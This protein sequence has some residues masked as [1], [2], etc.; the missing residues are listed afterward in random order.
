MKIRILALWLAVMVA[1]GGC[2]QSPAAPAASTSAA[3]GGNA[4]SGAWDEKGAVEITMGDGTFQAA[5]VGTSVKDKVLTITAGGTYVLSGR[6]DDG[7]IVIDAEDKDVQL[8]LN[9]ASLTC[10]DS[11][12]IYAKGGKLTLTL[13]EGTENTLSDGAEY[14]FAQGEDEPTGAVF[15]KDDLTIG[16][17]GT[18]T[19]NGRYQHGIAGKDDVAIDGG[20]LNVTAKADGIRGKDSLTV[21]G[22]TITVEAG[23]DGLK[24]NNNED[25]SK[26]MVTLNGGIL[27]VTAGNDAV[28]AET[29]LLIAD[30]EYQLATGGGGGDGHYQD[31]ASRKGL[32]AGT[33]I[34]VTGGTFILDT[35]DDAVHSNGTVDVSGGTFTISTGDDGIHGDG[36]VSVSGGDINILK[37][38][39]GLEGLNVTV[40]DGVVHLIA[41]DDGINAAD[42]TAAEGPGA[43]GFGGGRPQGEVPPPQGTTPPG[44]GEPPAMPDGI[45]EQAAPQEGGAVSNDTSS[46]QPS[47]EK[48]AP[49]EA[50]SQPVSGEA[51]SGGG[52]ARPQRMGGGGPGGHTVNENVFIRISGGTVVVDAKGDGLDS[53][54]ALYMDGGTVLVNGPSGSG[55]GALDYDGECVVT[56]GTLIAAGSAGMA[57]GISESSAQASLMVYFTETQAADTAVN[58]ST[59]DGKSIVTFVPKKEFQT[60]L[61]S[62]P[63]LK[64]GDT[65]ALSTGGTDTVDEDGFAAGGSWSG[66]E[67][68]AEITL[69]KVTKVSQDGSAVTGGGMMG[70][71]GGGGRRQTPAQ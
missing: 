28:Q 58:L 9:G 49:G 44:E 30:G 65:V 39:E 46:S 61:I 35:A 25:T 12:P 69:E 5:G 57:Q 51:S 53:N 1:L 27:Q 29:E 54:G 33:G 36:A 55:D 14:T 66:G 19:V 38:Y 4:A 64:E 63:D 8:V 6:L 26:G 7:Q 15:S 32:K 31:E 37:C 13:A 20:I 40:T 21:N 10:A 68:L 42:P 59:G 41:S 24:S 62:S 70:R 50:S 17:T 43:G 18:L 47:P 22:G 3:S 71:G 45:P 56:G 16:G 67:K 60:L 2:G 23:E 48:A 34:T 11:A 52:A